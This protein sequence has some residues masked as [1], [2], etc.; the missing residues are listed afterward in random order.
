MRKPLPIARALLEAPYGAMF[1]VVRRREVPVVEARASLLRTLAGR[2]ADHAAGRLVLAAVPELAGGRLGATDPSALAALCLAAGA[3]PN[4]LADR[5]KEEMVGL[6][7]GTGSL[8]AHL[9]EGFPDQWQALAAWQEERR[10]AANALQE[11][12]RAIQAIQRRVRRR[13]RERRRRLAVRPRGQL[14]LFLED[15]DGVTMERATCGALDRY[16]GRRLP[17]GRHCPSS[18]CKGRLVRTSDLSGSGWYPTL[19]VRCTRCDDVPDVSEFAT[20]VVVEEQLVIERRMVEVA[21]S[22]HSEEARALFDRAVEGWAADG[23]AGEAELEGGYLLWAARADGATYAE[24]RR[25][26]HLAERDIDHPSDL[27]IAGFEKYRDPLD[28]EGVR[29]PA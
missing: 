5:F 4:E 21:A 10:R 24:L 6:V 1:I 28:F 14:Y 7:G 20:T 2:D 29:P 27:G 26:G 23:C 12:R 17:G 3:S 11:T 25:Y 22:L 19:E 18:G 13:E 15:F 8:A 9:R 16:D